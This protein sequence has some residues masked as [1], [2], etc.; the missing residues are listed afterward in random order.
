MDEPEFR[1]KV[2]KKLLNLITLYTSCFEQTIR[3]S[4]CYKKKSKCL[5]KLNWLVQNKLKNNHSNHNK[6]LIEYLFLIPF[7]LS[8]LTILK[9]DLKL[10]KW[11]ISY[12][13]KYQNRVKNGTIL[14][15]TNSS[16]YFPS[17]EE[18]CICFLLHFNL[19]LPLSKVIFLAKQLRNSFPDF[20]SCIL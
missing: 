12:L 7:F 20:I 3:S 5:G 19:I 18:D 15:H 8:V 6:L 10:N 11:C 1:F 4:D 13:P 2:T 16:S 14:A 17:C 9:I